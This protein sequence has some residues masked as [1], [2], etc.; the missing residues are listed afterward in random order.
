MSDEKRT[1]RLAEQLHDD[2]QIMH[3]DSG[4]IRTVGLVGQR[5][6]AH[7]L[8]LL[9]EHPH[10][11]GEDPR[12]LLGRVLSMPDAVPYDRE[13]NRAGLCVLLLAAVERR[14]VN[15]PTSGDAA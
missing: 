15:D 4:D 9:R 6:I 14:D 11:A 3:L 8:R 12:Q 1:L 13:L 2:A 7:S 10:L 5:V